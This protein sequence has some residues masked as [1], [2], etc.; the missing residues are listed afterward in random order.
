VDGLN[1]LEHESRYSVNYNN[2]VR[3]PPLP[4][5]GCAEPLQELEIWERR[6]GFIPNAD[7]VASRLRRR[8][9]LVRGGHP[10]LYLYHWSRGLAQNVPRELLGV[11]ARKYPLAPVNEPAVFVHG[12]R[13]GQ[14]VGPV[15]QQ[16]QQPVHPHPHQHPQQVQL[17][18]QNQ[19][20]AALEARQ[21][22]VQAQAQAQAAAQ[23][24]RVPSSIRDDV[25]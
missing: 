4:H 18:A 16:Q 24:R 11:P 13:R 8:Y 5:M 17:A 3:T 23:V 2:A 15:V 25:G 14:R 6:F 1:Y 19:H 7:P 20:M 12:E 9:R 21:R 22:Q 10:N